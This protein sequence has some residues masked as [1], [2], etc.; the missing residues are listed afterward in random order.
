MTHPG[1]AA[2]GAL[3]VM[4]VSAAWHAANVDRRAGLLLV[5][6]VAASGFAFLLDLSI[7]LRNG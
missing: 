4:A 6:W 3:A 5:P 2:A 7:A 1:R